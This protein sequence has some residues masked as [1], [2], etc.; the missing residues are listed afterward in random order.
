MVA[1]MLSFCSLISTTFVQNIRYRVQTEQTNNFTLGQRFTFQCQTSW[2]VFFDIF[3]SIFF[4]E[5]GPTKNATS[6][7]VCPNKSCN[8][9]Y[10]SRGGYFNHVQYECGGR[11]QFQCWLCDRKFSQKASLKSHLGIVHHIIGNY[12]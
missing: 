5:S 4:S 9:V 12:V 8:R 7:F 3:F 2:N 10:K 11:K 6:A 1:A